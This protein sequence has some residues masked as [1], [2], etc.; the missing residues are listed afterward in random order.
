MPSAVLAIGFAAVH[1]IPG[2]FLEFASSLSTAAVC[3]PTDHGVCTAD[4]GGWCKP[5]GNCCCADSAFNFCA[6]KGEFDF[7][8]QAPPA[9]PQPPS[10]PAATCPETSEYNGK[11]CGGAPKVCHGALGGNSLDWGSGH[12]TVTVY[13]AGGAR[14]GA[15]AMN[16]GK[17]VKG[18]PVEDGPQYYSERFYGAA[19]PNPAFASSDINPNSFQRGVCADG[20]VACIGSYPMDGHPS[21]PEGSVC[22]AEYTGEPLCFELSQEGKA[23]DPQYSL[24]IMVTEN[25]GGNCRTG[26]KY[27][28]WAMPSPRPGVDWPSSASCA[29]AAAANT[30]NWKLC[31]ATEAEWRAGEGPRGTKPRPLCNGECNTVTAKG[32][33]HTLMPPDQLNPDNRCAAAQECEAD[34]RSV[35]GDRRYNIDNPR[36]LGL[37]ECAKDLPGGAGWN[38]WCSGVYEHFDIGLD[39]SH[40]DFAK[41]CPTAD[42]CVVLKRRIP[43]GPK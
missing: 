1:L 17:N 29:E 2:R 32:A 39:K 26:P 15:F 42:N 28:H 16:F 34:I 43:C 33:V 35:F 5:P 9:P 13:E 21:G 25:C 6:Q 11:A 36:A 18:P 27:P 37:N 8:C 40:P 20:I 30:A 23:F 24:E 38:D 10:A 31:Y 3:D 19:Y 14:G 12:A 22:G 7:A 4:Q 41:L